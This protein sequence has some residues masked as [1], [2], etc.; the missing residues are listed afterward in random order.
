MS[1]PTDKE[2]SDAA[3]Q[4][5]V[6][7]QPNESMLAVV[8]RIQ[9]IVGGD[10]WGSDAFVAYGR[11]GP[12]E[13]AVAYLRDPVNVENRRAIKLRIAGVQQAMMESEYR[14]LQDELA[15]MIE[16]KE[17]GEHVP[18]S[19]FQKISDRHARVGEWLSILKPASCSD[20]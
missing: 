14:F 6:E 15:A 12:V 17:C 7:R 3:A 19:E 16:A 5:L 2:K 11:T 13:A 10:C 20:E 18:D 4:D 9:K 8:Q 1:C